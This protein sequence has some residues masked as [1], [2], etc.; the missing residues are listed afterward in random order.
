M[1]SSMSTVQNHINWKSYQY[2]SECVCVTDV[3]SALH[4]GAVQASV[5]MK[6]QCW[7]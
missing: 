3:V 5:N 1:E 2:Q 6:H 7:Q 4:H